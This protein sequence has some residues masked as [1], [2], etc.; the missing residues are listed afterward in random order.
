MTMYCSNSIF[1]RIKY[2]VR[3][4]LCFDLCWVYNSS[5]AL[6]R[7]VS[8]RHSYLFNI[9]NNCT[10]K[11]EKQQHGYKE[12]L[13]GSYWRLVKATSLPWH[14]KY[15]FQRW[16]FSLI[17]LEIWNVKSL[18]LFNFVS[19]N[20]LRKWYRK[21]T[22]DYRDKYFQSHWISTSVPV[23]FAYLFKYVSVASSHTHTPTHTNYSLRYFLK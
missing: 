20:I 22:W 8:A 14:Y 6:E 16:I 13:L 15:T 4:K 18:G 3:L 1:V 9:V 19:W 10:E 17:L 2:T 7:A 11:S 21:R 12:R 23:H 5:D